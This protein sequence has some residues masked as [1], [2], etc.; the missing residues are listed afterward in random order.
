MNSSPSTPIKNPNNQPSS[1]ITEE[2]DFPLHQSSITE[3]KQQ[4]SRIINKNSINPTFQNN[5]NNNKEWNQ[6]QNTP[7]TDSD[8]ITISAQKL[9]QML[10]LIKQLQD[11]LDTNM[12]SVS[13][14][15]KF[16]QN[17]LH[18]AQMIKLVHE[19]LK[20]TLP[21]NTL[22]ISIHEFKQWKHSGTNILIL[23]QHFRNTLSS[24]ELDSAHWVKT[25]LTYLEGSPI[26]HEF[27]RLHT[28]PN[29]EDDP[30]QIM[31]QSMANRHI[32][33]KQ[34]KNWSLEGVFAE[35]FRIFADPNTLIN[36]KDYFITWSTATFANLP[37][38]IKT[39]E[40]LVAQ[41]TN[42]KMQQSN[43]I[44]NHS[45]LL[46]DNKNFLYNTINPTFRKNFG[47]SCFNKF[48]QSV[49]EA[50][51]SQQYQ[52]MVKALLDH[53]E[54]EKR[55]LEIYTKL[56]H[57]TDI[58]R[59]MSKQDPKSNHSIED[60]QIH[61]IQDATPVRPVLPEK[62]LNNPDWIC[63][64]C[65]K[66]GHLVE[67]CFVKNPSLMK[68]WSVCGNCKKSGHTAKDCKQH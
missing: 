18:T 16:I 10:T 24:T 61:F 7:Q 62:K 42:F 45:E 30:M 60:K 48:Q 35:L 56:E 34:F 68:T 4:A 53:I 22:T 59:R 41:M 21:N 33:T 31:Y 8:E 27:L 20:K 19:Q 38:G 17:P 1:S 47:I 15:Q 64:F 3:T 67:T 66:P 13:S 58:S 28:L 6:Q 36:I 54:E 40:S 44:Q 65:S 43:K 11:Q 14:P 50:L 5:L 46:D 23:L 49:T 51:L 9:N 55:D 12:N 57:L 32:S 63:S 52:P 26:M 2:E 39:Y 29:H 37:E 25:I